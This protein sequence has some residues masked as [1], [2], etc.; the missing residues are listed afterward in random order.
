MSVVLRY[1]EASQTPT[2]ST[3]KTSLDFIT[4]T[5][6]VPTLC[7]FICVKS[8]R[9]I[10][11]CQHFITT[12]QT[13]CLNPREPG[14]D[15][16]CFWGLSELYIANLETQFKVALVLALKGLRRLT[17]TTK[18]KPRSQCLCPRGA[19]KRNRTRDIS[20]CVVVTQGLIFD[21]NDWQRMASPCITCWWLEWDASKEY[22][23]DEMTLSSQQKRLSSR[24]V[25]RCFCTSLCAVQRPPAAR[26][27]QAGCRPLG[28]P[29]FPLHDM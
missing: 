9:F 7:Y 4:D 22:R 1:P 23:L 17:T 12:V 21:S 2:C 10:H 8:I 11:I 26:R 24:L 5:I 3:G 18:Q 19:Q 6:E 25:E 28:C 14:H 29:F 27:M 16:R 20:P 15:T 13:G